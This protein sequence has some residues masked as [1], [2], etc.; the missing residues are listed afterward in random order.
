MF[1][2][3]LTIGSVNIYTQTAFIITALFSGFF[4]FWKEGKK[5][6]FIEARLL[7]LA[8]ICVLAAFVGARLIGSFGSG[9]YSWGGGVLGFFAGVSWFINYEGWSFLKVGDLLSPAICLSTAF[10][11]LGIFLGSSGNWADLFLAF[12]YLGCFSYFAY[13]YRSK[14]KTGFVLYV[15]LFLIG[16]LHLV[17]EFFHK[18]WFGFNHLVALAILFLGVVGLRRGDYNIMNIRTYSKDFLD[19]MKFLL[20][21]KSKS[22][23]EDITQLE[24]GDLLTDPSRVELNADIMEDA[25]ELEEHAET[26]VLKGNMEEV[27]E[28]VEKSVESIERGTYGKCVKCGEL[29]SK[30][31]LEANPEAKTCIK[32]AA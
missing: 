28:S 16:I 5:Q 10:L 20:R 26:E 9:T 32:C 24:E 19:K 23:Q 11:M 30:K 27:L 31:R 3:L 6:G 2:I 22:L 7:D 14:S 4:W 12:L 15:F 1:P 21:R 8:L 13:T 25:G 18:N 17:F 29:I